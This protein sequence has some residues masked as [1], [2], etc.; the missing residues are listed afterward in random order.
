MRMFKSKYFKNSRWLFSKRNSYILEKN[1]NNLVVFTESVGTT[2]R[3][4]FIQ[5]CSVLQLKAIWQ[6]V[7]L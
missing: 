7:P 5:R 2:I 6:H 3:Q 4:L 1:T